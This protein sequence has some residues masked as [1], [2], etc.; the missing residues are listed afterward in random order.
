MD[1]DLPEEEVVGLGAEGAAAV[2]E[3]D[4]DIADRDVDTTADRKRRD[5]HE[6]V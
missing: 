3:W 4:R 6:A 2:L 1:L 5:G